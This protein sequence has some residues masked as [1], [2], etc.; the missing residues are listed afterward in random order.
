[1]VPIPGGRLDLDVT[2]LLSGAAP[3][4]PFTLFVDGSHPSGIAFASPRAL[5]PARR[6]H[7]DVLVR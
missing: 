7:L 3:G 4:K 6:P 5:D 2:E 1:L